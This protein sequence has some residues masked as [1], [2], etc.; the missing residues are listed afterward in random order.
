MSGHRQDATG[1]VSLC[2]HPEAGD[3]RTL[4]AAIYA[5][6]AGRLTLSDGNPCAGRWSTYEVGTAAAV[7]AIPL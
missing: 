5:P 4:S 2:Q 6:R 3:A 7:P 1:R